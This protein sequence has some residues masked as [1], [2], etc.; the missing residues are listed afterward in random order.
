MPTNLAVKDALLEKALKA[1]GLRTKK[2]TV[3]KALEEFI[4]RRQ[5]RKILRAMG[6]IEFREGWGYKTDRQDRTSRR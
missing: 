1:G 4:Q 3:T 2:E 6:S 5:Q